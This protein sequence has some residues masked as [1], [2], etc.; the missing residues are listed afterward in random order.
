MFKVGDKVIYKGVPK[1]FKR[2]DHK[3]VILRKTFEQ[4]YFAIK[5]LSGAEL[6]V[7]SDFL[8]LDLN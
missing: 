2:L 5:L 1:D 6:L 3:A 4:N 7:S 8:S